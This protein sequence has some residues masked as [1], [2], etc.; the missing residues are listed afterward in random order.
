[1][2]RS[3][4]AQLSGQHVNPPQGVPP[5]RRPFWFDVPASRRARATLLALPLIL[6]S[7]TGTPAA[8]ATIYVGNHGSD[9]ASCG[10][11][12]AP[13]RTISQGVRVAA[14][15]DRIVVQPGV[16]G[17]VDGDGDFVSPGD[18]PAQVDEGC[19][20][21]ISVD[22]SVTIVSEAGAGATILRGAIDSMFTVV[23][24]APNVTL[25]RK[26]QGFAIVGDLQH[27]G[28][29]VRVSSRAIG[30]RVE[31][32]LFSRL[33]QGLFV[34]GDGSRIVGNRI[35]EVFR[36]GIHAEGSGMTIAANV[37]EQ[38]GTPGEN[39]SALHVVGRGSVGHVIDRNL[40]VGNLG[41]GIYVDDGAGNA[42]TSPHA[43]TDN[44]VVGNRAAGIK[45]VLG[46]SSGGARINGNSLYANDGE[47]GGNCGLMTLS[48]GPAIDATNN[49][50]GSPAGPGP[51]PS[52]DVCSVGTAPQTGAAA[53][54]PF[55]RVAPPMR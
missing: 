5:A 30:A 33:D 54:V 46:K 43:V 10:A 42:S 36:Q 34:A 49:W 13:C 53:A 38:I 35:A 24:D 22:K 50:W 9:G 29:G 1:M 39:S 20:C 2:D 51:D 32:N 16:Y 47:S 41:I 48:A 14:D 40:V 55:V 23:I 19:E 18:E 37:L 7:L 17:D 31:G 44:L 15:G 45:V 52:D 12:D 28:L 21:L 8:A 25:G 11:V 4:T 6:V 27:D 26:K 3:T